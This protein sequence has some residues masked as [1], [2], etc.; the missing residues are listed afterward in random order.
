MSKH[1]HL[2]TYDAT[3]SI[4][5]LKFKF[6]QLLLTGTS[7]VFPALQIL[8]VFVDVGVSVTRV[9]HLAVMLTQY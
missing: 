3:L 1:K 5:Y 8:Q 2:D 9:T 6:A 4:A 7:M